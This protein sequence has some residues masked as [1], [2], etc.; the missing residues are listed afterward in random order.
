[1]TTLD[2]DYLENEQC[3]LQG[4]LLADGRASP[5]EYRF[6]LTS[7]DRN[8]TMYTVTADENGS[9]GE[10][11]TKVVG[12]LDRGKSYV[13]QAYVLNELGMGVGQMK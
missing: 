1:M 3:R 2:L 8:S 11:F 4:K 6:I 9:K 5:N 13:Y 10:E 7:T 12:D